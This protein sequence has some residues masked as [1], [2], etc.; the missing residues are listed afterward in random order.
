VYTVFS[1]E[2]HVNTFKCDLFLLGFF[3]RISE[4]VGQIVVDLRG[5]NGIHFPGD[6]KDFLGEN[7]GDFLGE[8]AVDKRSHLK[9]LRRKMKILSQN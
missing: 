5:E 2:V 3:L 6:L 1:P 9:V 4:D 8:N 7:I